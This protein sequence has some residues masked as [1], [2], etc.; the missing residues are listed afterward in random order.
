MTIGIGLARRRRLA[1]MSAV[2]A[3]LV[4][5]GG[6]CAALRKTEDL[7]SPSAEDNLGGPEGETDPGTP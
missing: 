7:P 2:M 5:L 1:I 3:M 6:A 4:F